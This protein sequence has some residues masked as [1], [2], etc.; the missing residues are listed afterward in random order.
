MKTLF[1]DCN[2]QLG[3]VWPRVHGAGDPPIALNT[4]PFERGDLAH[5][6][7]DHD[8]V[9]DDHSFM[10]TELVRQCPNL[11]HIV[12]LG[13]GAASYMNVPEIEALGIGVHTIRG[14]GDTAV[15]EHTIALMMAACRGVARMD[16]AV[17][18]GIWQ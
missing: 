9:I 4:A 1:I 17:R 2:P 7:G 8:I 12:F 10:P 11:K 5:V 13:T 15:A 18:G 14:Y 3:A 6:I 16:R